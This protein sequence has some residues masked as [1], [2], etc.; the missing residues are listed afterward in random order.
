[1]QV[2]EG[3]QV[4]PGAHAGLEDHRDT[5][6]VGKKAPAL[7]RSSGRSSPCFSAQTAFQAPG[8]SPEQESRGPCPQGGGRAAENMGPNPQDKFGPCYML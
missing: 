2:S 6:Q 1:M 5:P 8:Q 7:Q 4:L 3:S